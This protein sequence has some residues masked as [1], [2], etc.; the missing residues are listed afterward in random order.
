MNM[1][2][3][4]CV[5]SSDALDPNTQ[6]FAPSISK[7][8]LT[9]GSSW[10]VIPLGTARACWDAEVSQPTSSPGPPRRTQACPCCRCL[11]G[12]AAFFPVQDVEISRVIHVDVHWLL[13]SA[14][15]VTEYV[16]GLQRCAHD[17]QLQL[18]QVRICSRTLAEGEKRVDCCLFGHSQLR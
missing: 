12:A 1:F 4:H 10:F 14:A 13:C 7:C 6:L 3:L 16:T 18:L 2:V 5:A 9:S 17:L 8:V 15:K 11:V